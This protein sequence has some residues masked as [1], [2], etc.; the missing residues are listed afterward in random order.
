[1]SNFT[2]EWRIKINSVAYTN[3]TLA[4]LTIVSGRTDIYS[5]AVAGYCRLTLINIGQSAVVIEMNNSLSVEIK[6]STGTYI[7]IF[8]GSVSEV[9]I[10][11]TSVGSS[12][13][14]QSVSVTALG[15]LSRLPKALTN[16]VLSQDYDGN[17]ILS[18]LQDLLLNNWS[19]VPAA[20]TWATYSP[21]ADTWADAENTGLGEID[22]PGNY[23]LA[24]RTSSRIDMYSLV[25]AL[26]TS[27]LGYLYET[28]EGQIAYADST[29]RSIYL[30]TNGYTEITANDANAKGLK[31]R[32]KVGDVRNSVSIK[33]G[34]NSALT[35]SV[36][37]TDSITTY[38]Q[39]G[40][41]I[42]TTIKG[43]VD[44]T[45]QA[46][47][48]L[49][50]RANP[51]PIFESISYALTNPDIDNTDRD[52]LLNVF[53]GQPLNISNLPSNMNSGSFQGFVE[54]WTFQASYNQLNLNL[55]VS[56]IAFSLQAMD[57]ADVSVLE[58]WSTISATLDW[59]HALV[60]S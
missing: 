19:E 40:Q 48:Y 34:T 1:V 26:A 32:T 15:A 43:L 42:T 41:V 52:S 25:S 12:A 60:V 54:G 4:T 22:T 45:S 9:S 24:A 13:Y 29:H 17:Q 7:P 20:L 49:T 21:A 39:L 38:G 8:G 47:F 37:D 14:T 50:L 58:T 30:A 16:G 36:E 18:I 53:M 51:Q 23:E 35:V 5:Q 33:Y 46:N 6:N 44:A 28:A 10:E 3:V 31:I 57:W 2:P 27:G 55:L 59:A 56:P 11:V